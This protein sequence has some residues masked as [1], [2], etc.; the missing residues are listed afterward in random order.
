MYS[1]II[2]TCPRDSEESDLR[3]VG[4]G[5]P[6]RTG[7]TW[8]FQ[9]WSSGGSC[10]GWPASVLHPQP[11]GRCGKGFT[12]SQKASSGDLLCTRRVCKRQTMSWPSCLGTT[13]SR[14]PKPHCSKRAAKTQ[15]TGGAS[16]MNPLTFGVKAGWPSLVQNTSSKMSWKAF[17]DTPDWSALLIRHYELLYLLF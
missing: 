1:I 7:S 12:G 5:I 8:L 6:Q 2:T 16:K 14:H 15:G 11:Q 4:L 17:V 9:S 10:R 13:H 3:Q